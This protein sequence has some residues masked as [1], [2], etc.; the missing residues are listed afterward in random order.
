MRT[1]CRINNRKVDHRQLKAGRLIGR[2]TKSKMEIQFSRSFR[3]NSDQKTYSVTMPTIKHH[4]NKTRNNHIPKENWI[5]HWVG[6][7][8]RNDKWSKRLK[9][10][11]VGA[12]RRSYS[13]RLSCP[14]GWFIV[15]QQG[16]AD[17]V[18]KRFIDP[19]GACAVGAFSYYKSH[20]CA[21]ARDCL[22]SC[23]LE[24]LKN[25]LTYCVWPS[26]VEHWR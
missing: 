14:Q 24:K 12:G 8:C 11:R 5:Y 3:S 13:I 21:W 9:G 26:D 22:F 16:L 10:A 23:L 2:C 18:L 6:A 7:R 25:M 1:F 20:S 4:N 15:S 19:Y 17:P